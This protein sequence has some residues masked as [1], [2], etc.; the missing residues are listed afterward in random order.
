[1]FR[2]IPSVPDFVALEREI[3]ARWEKAAVFE[4]SI[5]ER[6]DRPEFVFYEGPPT[7]NGRPGL[8]HVWS[9]VYKDVFCRFQAMRGYQVPRR[10]GWDTHG[11]PVEVE[12]ERSLGFSGKNEIEQYGVAAF[13]EAC[14]ASVRTYVE[15]WERF[16][17]RI[18]FWV[19]IDDAYWTFDTTYVES[20][21]WHL[22]QLFDKGLLVEDLKVVPYCPRCGTALSSHEL[23]QADVYRDVADLAA[24]VRFPITSGGPATAEAL[25][26]WT[27][28][29]WTLVSNTAVAVNPDLDY[30]IVDGL[31]VAATRAEEVLGAGALARASESVSGAALVGTRYRRPL[32]LVPQ[33]ESGDGWRVVPASFVT[34][35]EGTGLVHIAPAFGADDFALGKREGLPTINP[36]GPDGRFLEAGWLSGQPTRGANDTIV[37]RLDELGLI[38]AAAPHVHSYP[39]CW[40]CGSPLIYWGKPSWYVATSTRKAELIA[41]NETVD[42]QPPNVKHG[43][44][45]EWLE[46]NVDW[47]LSR[48][49]FWGTPLPIWRCDNG[50]LRCIA[51]LAELSE[52]TGRDVT[53]LDP[54]R[55]VIDNVRFGCPDCG[56]EMSRVEAVIDAWFDSGSMPAAQWGYPKV[57]GSSEKLRFPADFVC[58]AVDQTR[59]W[60]YSLLAVNVLVHGA[61]P[62]RNVLSL[63]HVVDANGKKMSKT[64]GNAIDPWSILDTRGAEPLRWWMFHQGSPWTATRTSLAAID[65]STG[66]V[67]MTLWN[68]W[69]FFSTYASLHHF[70]PADS[71]IPAPAARPLFDRWLL[72]RLAATVDEVTTALDG[73]EA[74]NG[75]DAI[76][77]FVDDLSNWYV[78]ANRRRFWR[79]D[80]ALDATETLAAQA[81]LHEALVTLSLL[82]GPFCPFLADH[83]WI[84]LTG[85]DDR[86]SVHLADWPG[87]PAAWRDERL[88]GE[89]ALARR[90][91]SL[92]RAARGESGVKVRQPLRRALVVLPPDSPSLPAGVV[93]EELNVDE[94]VRTEQM[95]EIV[96]Y[97]LVPNFRLLGPRL[98]E[99]VKDVRGALTSLNGEEVVAHLERGEP[100]VLQTSNG[101][102]ELAGDEIEVRVRGREGFAV[103]RQGTAAV[104]LDLEIDP[105]LALRGLV[106]DVVRQV[107]SLRRE[108]GFEMSDRIELFLTGLDELAPRATEMGRDVLAVRVV[109]EP[110]TGTAHRIEL[111]D[112]DRVA[113][114]YLAIAP[115]G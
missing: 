52:Y 8:H 20:V 106:R 38:V 94:V 69:S 79:T 31:V 87:L 71:D 91:V 3:A 109:F 74:E 7:A 83:M 14:R 75:A 82:L 66:E 78:R 26:I 15:E 55:P 13:V 111:D 110:G 63:G 46:N 43:R 42:W 80:P 47:A 67:L 96:A 39:H 10:A 51:S 88:E 9:R 18:G 54:H 77:S 35:D 29:P 112:A 84:E 50:H 33:P 12:V 115:H 72:S 25:V 95:G 40:R 114:A 22:Q 28:T 85:A 108:L 27:T 104:A 76:A 68:T 92:G 48:D 64:L 62:Y 4:R 30:V 113:A 17:R 60:F 59:G 49:R 56:A 107:Q 100:V 73:Y 16:T 44:F 65:A 102:V 70:D 1:M 24:Y 98:G 23:A 99:A 11:L 21:W 81:T 90:V 34:A 101:P 53:G 5:S 57:P 89:M 6:A 37:E 32:D 103:S 45:G 36:V 93:E 58:E 41:A 105:E 86:A 61:A 2:P 97:E 19:D